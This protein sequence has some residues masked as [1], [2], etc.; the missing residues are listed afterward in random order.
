MFVSPSDGQGVDVKTYDVGNL[1]WAVGGQ[2]SG[3]QIGELYV[4]YTIR[5]STPQRNE[6]AIA[7]AAS[8]VVVPTAGVTKSLPLGTANSVAGGL[9]ISPTS[10]TQSFLPP[11]ASGGSSGTDLYV[12]EPGQYIMDFFLNGTGLATSDLVVAPVD[13]AGATASAY[14]VV[15]N[16]IDVANSAGT[17]QNVVSTLN[18]AQPG[19]IRLSAAAA[20]TLTALVMRASKYAPSSS[21]S[22][23]A[24]LNETYV[25]GED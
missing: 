16:I 20:T 10:S 21:Q 22:I 23:G 8:K 2:S 15:S 1:W 4:T 6:I 18:F 17:I 9:P 24:T 11:P 5:L 13:A 12:R 7:K 14:N 19:W 25:P 3:A